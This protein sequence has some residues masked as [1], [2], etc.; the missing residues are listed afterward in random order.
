MLAG[1]LT[2]A[3]L[4]EVYGVEAAVLPNAVGHPAN[5]L[6]TSRNP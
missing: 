2:A 1:L 5:Q 3:R 6:D 4:A